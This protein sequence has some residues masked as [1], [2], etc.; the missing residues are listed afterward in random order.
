MSSSWR[1]SPKQSAILAGGVILLA[2]VGG[3]WATGHIYSTAAAMDLIDAV[4][5]SALY[6]GSAIATSAATTLALM[7]TLVAFVHR[8]DHD[9]DHILYKRIRL[10]AQ[11][12][13]ISL[14]G[15]VVLLLILTLPVGEFDKIPSDWFRWLYTAIYAAVVGLSALLVATVTLLLGTLTSLIAVITPSDDV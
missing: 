11:L 5:S 15:S 6:L 2:G 7:L 4:R 3:R 13:T 12:S 9:F 10:I 1:L 8:T 14:T